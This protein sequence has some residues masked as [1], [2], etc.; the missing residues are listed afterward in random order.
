MVILRTSNKNKERKNQKLFKFQSKI[1]RRDYISSRMNLS[2]LE[3]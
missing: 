2:V 3:A 1:Q